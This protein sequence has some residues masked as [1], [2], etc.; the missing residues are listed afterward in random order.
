MTRRLDN[1][2]WA[3]DRCCGCGTCM[4]ICSKGVLYWGAGDHPDREQRE[5]TLGL[6]RTPLDTCSFCQRFCEEGCPRLQDEWVP[7]KPLRLASAR[8]QGIV[9]SGEPTDV[10][11]HLLIGALSAELI[12]GAILTDMD[13]WEMKPVVKVT[14]TVAEIADNL[15][16]QHLWVPTLGAL[17]EAVYEQG[18]RALAVV[19]TPCV[20]QGTR[21][22][23][24]AQNT[25][26][27][28]Y[29]KAI[30]LS[31][32]AFCTGIHRPNLVNGFL[33]DALEIPLHSIRRLQASPRDD[34]LTA[35]LWDGSTRSVSLS[36]LEEYTQPGC[37]RCN[38]YLGESADLAVGTVGAKHDACTVIVRSRAGEMCLRAA[39]DLGLLEIGDDVD[40]SALERAAGDKERRHRAQEFDRQML[41]ML[42]ALAEPRK[43]AAVRQA[44]VSLYES[45]R[46]ELRKS[47]NEEADCHVTCAQC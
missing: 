17:N 45:R 20:S 11:K 18:L 13:P 41:V 4:A 1:E 25:R 15:G 9:T 44:Y 46:A 23:K 47:T 5:K 21:R 36:R 8:T 42:D 19:G 33:T 31:I 38:D 2:V 10:I 6:S 39:V 3:L 29:Q 27:S 24:G 28:P 12:D 35:I 37:A 30:R 43:R 14:T 7:I 40:V 34:R 32:A 26:L 22:L 16:S